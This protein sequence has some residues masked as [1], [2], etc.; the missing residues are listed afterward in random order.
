[1]RDRRFN[2]QSICRSRR[3]RLS[4]IQK[5]EEQKQGAKRDACDWC[6]RVPQTTVLFHYGLTDRIFLLRRLS[7]RHAQ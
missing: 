1:M 5:G 3:Q 2:L 6:S 7:N 4:Q